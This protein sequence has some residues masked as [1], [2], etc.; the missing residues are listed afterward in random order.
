MGRLAGTAAPAETRRL[1][2]AGALGFGPITIVL[3]AGLGTLEPLIVAGVGG[4]LPIHRLFTVLFV[5]AA[6]LIAGLSAGALGLALG[7]P[8]LALSWLWQVGVASALA[9]LVIHLSM[10]A[11]GW[12][13]GGPGAAERATMLT[14]LGMGALGS[15]L[16][17]GGVLGLALRRAS[18]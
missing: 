6:F 2:L 14:V 15:A 4:A 16:A 17:G 1:A 3:A 12:V 9:F 5:P 10:E 13:V 11:A 8:R 7:R 18:L